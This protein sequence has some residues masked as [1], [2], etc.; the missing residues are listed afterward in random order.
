MSRS[1]QPKPKLTLSIPL[2]S[3]LST[4]I[5]TSLIDFLMTASLTAS[6]SSW[7][8]LSGYTF[9]CSAHHTKTQLTLKLLLYDALWQLYKGENGTHQVSVTVFPAFHVCEHVVL[10]AGNCAKFTLIVWW[11][12]FT[13][14]SVLPHI[15]K[16]C[17]HDCQS[18]YQEKERQ[19]ESSCSPTIHSVTPSNSFPR[20][21]IVWKDD[22]LENTGKHNNGGGESFMFYNWHMQSRRIQRSWKKTSFLKLEINW[23]GT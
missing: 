13:G 20:E 10:Q 19:G 8:T 11:D 2:P 1:V 5:P 14:A 21:G 22:P 12:R 6:S 17:R 15:L 18:L 16:T 4:S 3:V 7:A 9:F 23:V